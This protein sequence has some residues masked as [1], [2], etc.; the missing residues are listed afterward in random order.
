MNCTQ[1]QLTWGQAARQQNQYFRSGKWPHSSTGSHCSLKW[2]SGAGQF[3]KSYRK[4]DF[5]LSLFFC[6]FLFGFIIYSNHKVIFHQKYG[7]QAIM[8]QL[9]FWNLLWYEHIANFPQTV[10]IIP[11]CLKYLSEEEIGILNCDW[12]WNFQNTLNLSWITHKLKQL[13]HL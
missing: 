2:A 4:K 10:Y 8:Q 6:S 9:S 5:F 12:K 11:H 7:V 13:L 1:I 3:W